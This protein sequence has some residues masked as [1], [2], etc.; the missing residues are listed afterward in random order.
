MR[1]YPTVHKKRDEVLSVWGPYSKKW[2]GISHI[3]E[4]DQGTLMEFSVF[5]SQYRGMTQLPVEI[6]QGN[7]I[8]WD[9]ETDQSRYTYRF[10]LEW[11]DQVYTD[12][13]YVR[14]DDG[15]IGVKAELVNNTNISQAEV[16][17]YLIHRSVGER[18]M[19]Q[20]PDQGVI[21]DGLMYEELELKSPKR[22]EGLN[23]DGTLTGEMAGT[24]YFHG[25]ALSGL[26]GPYGMTGFFGQTPGDRVVYDLGRC[27]KKGENIYIRAKGKGKFAVSG[28]CSGS[29]EIHG[30]QPM[31]YN[32]PAAEGGTAK[33]VLEC[34]AGSGV[35]V[36]CIALSCE[37]PAVADRMDA[38]VPDLEEKENRLVVSY[39][40]METEYGIAWEGDTSEVREFRT[41]RPETFMP[42]MT[43]NHVSKVLT[44][45]GKDEYID[46]FIR[47]I[48]L[49]AGEKK[50][51]FGRIVCGQKGEAGEMLEHAKP[52]EQKIF[53]G[54][55]ENIQDPY[56]AGQ[57]RMRAVMMTN[58]V[59][60]VRLQG[61]YIRHFTPGKW[62]DSLYTWDNGFI[63]LG[64]AQ[65]NAKLAED[66]LNTYLMEPGNRHAAFVHH[67]S[68]V[69]V[70]A[71][72][73][74]TIFEKNGDLEFL[75]TYYPS[76]KQY[77]DFYAGHDPRSHMRMEETGLLRPFDYFYN[78]GGWDDYPPQKYIV[79][80]GMAGYTSPVINTCQ[81]MNFARIM[82]EAGELLG[83][84]TEG[85]RRDIKNWKDALQTYSYDS[86]SGY[87]SY[88]VHGEDGVSK[89]QTEKGENRNKGLDGAYPFMAD[90]CTETQKQALAEKIMSAAHMWTPIGISVVDQSASYYRPDGYWNG[91]V[92][93]PHQWFVFL[94]M[95]EQGYAEYAV[96]IAD[97]ALNLWKHETDAS[98]HCYEH[99]MVQ[100]GRGAGWHN[101]SGLSAPVVSWY[102]GF[103]VKGTVTAPVNLMVTKT[104]TGDKGMAIQL[105][106]F[107]GKSDSSGISYVVAVPEKSVRE[108]Y[109]NDI[110]VSHKE[111]GKAVLVP[112]PK[113]ADS[114]VVLVF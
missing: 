29:V 110:R 114:R 53:L 41:S 25:H 69:P 19:I 85:Y 72:V 88:V 13:T 1:S 4:R 44:D 98:Y 99:F 64:M 54:E 81:A 3:A 68:M 7:Y 52:L 86:E 48:F 39:P 15:S 9:A 107:K 73:Y 50:T 60:P 18:V 55:K 80:H 106:S 20:V 10:E 12:V 43:H 82:A 11:K 102:Y 38:V 66:C 47:P 46:I 112:V 30:D 109:V 100:S 58:V 108:V 76:M 75:R 94:G 6:Y 24:E 40:D 103:Y 21:L 17:H 51:L 31:F 104:E 95:L 63:A 35:A 83:E 62:W 8:P 113:D 2:A 23:F 59:F 16:L 27:A 91:S 45:D 61:S 65:L 57:R 77:Y 34:V 97:T 74:K 70:Q 90:A 96:R 36:D 71:Y 111:H 5:P 14:L 67:G 26:A 84:E 93:M 56:E 89:L 33:L 28:M 37:V 32:L 22:R 92:W 101:F 105:K 87:F 79:S 42:F 78:S 49:K